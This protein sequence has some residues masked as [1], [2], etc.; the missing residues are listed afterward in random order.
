MF[1]LLN[2]LFYLRILVCVMSTVWEDTDG[3]ANQYRCD[4]AIFLMTV[5][6]TSY[7][8]IIYRAMNAQGHGNNVV[9]EINATDKLY[10]SKQVE[11]VGKLAKNNTSNIGRLLSASKDVSVKFTD[12]C[13]NILNNEEILNRLRDSTK[14]ENK[15]SLFKFQS[16]IYSVKSNYD[17]NH[18]GMKM[19]CNNKRFSS[20]N[21]INGKTYPYGIKGILRHYHY[22]QDPKLG[23]VIVTIRRNP[24]NFHACTTILS[25]S[26]ASK[27]KEAI[28][29]PRY[30]GVYNYKYSQIL[31]CK[32]NSNIM[33]FDD[34]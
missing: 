30:G 29:H 16:H 8:I 14:I 24:C 22:W 33:I 3:C 20:F 19:R 31:G 13:I 18:R 9:N 26:W 7:G 11:L 4:L 6:L 23:Q 1:H 2:Q 21:G 25:L 12:H 5:L 34:D 27:I 17:V 32:N 28:N 10:L 15:E